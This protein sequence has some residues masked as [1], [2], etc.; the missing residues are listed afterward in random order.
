MSNTYKTLTIPA[1]EVKVGDV[2]SVAGQSLH[3]RAV[4]SAWGFTTIDGE[5]I[6]ISAGLKNWPRLYFEDDTEL[7]VRR[8]VDVDVDELAASAAFSAYLPEAGDL[9]IYEHWLRDKWIAAAKAAQ[10]VYDTHR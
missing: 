6:L 4:Y 7:I 2:L 5:A 9:S 1:S 3:V 10:E 8:P